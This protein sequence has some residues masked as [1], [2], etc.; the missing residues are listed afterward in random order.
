MVEIH[1]MC[2]SVSAQSFYDVYDDLLFHSLP[3]YYVEILCTDATE[4]CSMNTQHC[5]KNVWFYPSILT[6]KIV[7]HSIFYPQT[8]T[9]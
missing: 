6:E 9:A 8:C 1:F 3:G 4:M 7:F 2:Y 5:L